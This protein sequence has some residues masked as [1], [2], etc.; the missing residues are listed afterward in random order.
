MP[1][2][3][4]R[5]ALESSFKAAWFAEVG[6]ADGKAVIFTVDWPPIR[7]RLA[8]NFSALGPSYKLES[9]FSPFLPS[10]ERHSSCG[11]AVPPKTVSASDGWVG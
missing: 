4:D 7:A 2:G 8:R 5:V 10:R 6:I 11:I 1:L 9:G 3:N